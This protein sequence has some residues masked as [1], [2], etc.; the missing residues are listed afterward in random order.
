MMNSEKGIK[1]YIYIYIMPVYVCIV[2]VCT[3]I[4]IMPV[5]VY[6]VGVCMY[7]DNSCLCI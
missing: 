6:I 1:V 2:D 4:Y 7:I 5:Y 3:Y